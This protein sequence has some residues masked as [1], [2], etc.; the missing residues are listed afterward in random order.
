MFIN[1]SENHSEMGPRLVRG[2][3]AVAGL[4]RRPVVDV[5]EG[6]HHLWNGFGQ[7]VADV[8][9][10][11]RRFR[12]H[13]GLV[14][15][16]QRL[17]IDFGYGQCVGNAAKLLGYQGDPGGLNGYFRAGLARRGLL[18]PFGAHRNNR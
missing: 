6:D 15:G 16:A 18:S 2:L 3:G 4:F 11:L 8:C 17:Q 14:A 13:T 5:F 1:V 12:R 9:D 10:G 7:Q